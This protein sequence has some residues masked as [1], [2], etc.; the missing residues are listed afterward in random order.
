MNRHIHELYV[1]HFIIFDRKASTVAKVK[2]EGKPSI[3]CISI[4]CNSWLQTKFKN[5]NATKRSF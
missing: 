3:V 4:V 2:I 5:W 1:C